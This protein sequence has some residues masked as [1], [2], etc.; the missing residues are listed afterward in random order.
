MGSGGVVDTE[1]VVD[2]EAAVGEEL[3]EGVEPDDEESKPAAAESAL[4]DAGVRAEE[5]EPASEGSLVSR[6]LDSASTL[7]GSGESARKA[8]A[9]SLL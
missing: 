3:E 2:T 7:S 8:S 4:P 6:R 5:L 9:P 1:L